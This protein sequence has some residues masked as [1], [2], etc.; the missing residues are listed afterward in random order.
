MKQPLLIL[1]QYHEDERGILKYNN[2]F[3]LT[4]IK[5]FYTIEPVNTHIY[6]GWQAHKIEQRWFTAIKGTFE[7]KTLLID[8]WESPAKDLEQQRF[9]IQDKTLNILQVPA[10]YATCIRATKVQSVLGVFSDYPL[11]LPNDQYRYD[12]HYFLST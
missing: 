2:T 5:R 8:D 11:G 4:S 7:I 12:L 3:D 1:G 9:Y 10:G 6:R